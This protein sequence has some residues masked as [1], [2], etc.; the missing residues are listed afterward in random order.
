MAKAKTPEQIERHQEMRLKFRRLR[1]ERMAVDPVYAEAERAK[2]RADNKTYRARARAG[3]PSKVRPI[4]VEGEVAY[5]PL[6]RGLEAIID[7]VDVPL[8][9]GR[10]WY[11]TQEYGQKSYA[12]TRVKRADRPGQHTIKLHRLLMSDTNCREVDHADRNPLNNR[13]NNLRPATSA[14]N[15]ANRGL[16][17]NNRSGFKGVHF[18]LASNRWRASIRYCGARFNLGSFLSAEDAAEAY[19]LAA[20]RLN[21]EFACCR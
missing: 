7:A 9:E 13:R 21:G 18:H 19:K 8:V 5:I 12:A 15:N 3:K 14:Q 6:T 20:E 4:R 11:A 10:N 17:R 16:Q 1:R 2:K